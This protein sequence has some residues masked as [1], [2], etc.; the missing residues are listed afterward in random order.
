MSSHHVTS[1]AV[2]IMLALAGCDNRPVVA[3]EKTPFTVAGVTLGT[4]K[5]EVQALGRLG[6]CQQRTERL[7]SCNYTPEKERVLFLG[8]NVTRIT[9]QFMDDSPKVV[10]IHVSTVGTQISE[11]S[12]RWDW[13]LEGRCVDD[14]VADAVRNFSSDGRFAIEQINDMKLRVHAGF[15]CLSEDGRY[16]SGSSYAGVSNRQYTSTIEMFMVNTSAADAMNAALAVRKRI[17]AKNKALNAWSG[18]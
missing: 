3:T 4:D 10:S 6:S 18:S 13:K 2:L 14:H 11:L 16:V 5:E 9:Y 17:E 8:Q 15:S 12:V 1:F 7:A